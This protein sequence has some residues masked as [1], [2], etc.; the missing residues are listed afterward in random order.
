MIRF[1]QN[2]AKRIGKDLHISWKEV[3]L[4]EFTR[5]LNV[6]LEH[7]SKDTQTNVTVDNG[8]LTGEIAWAHLKEFPDYY[9]RLDKMEKLAK[10]RFKDVD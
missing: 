1:T 9:T 4:R 2:N 3:N 8:K 7:G 6:E 10:V 5:G